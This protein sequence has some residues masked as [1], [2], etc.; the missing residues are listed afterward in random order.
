ML[1]FVEPSPEE[2]LCHHSEGEPT[3][4]MISISINLCPE[5]AAC[6]RREELLTSS[7]LI[8]HQPSP[9]EAL[10]QQPAL[11]GGAQARALAISCP[12]R[13]IRPARGQ[14]PGLAW[15]SG[16][17]A[18]LPV[19]RGPRLAWLGGSVV[20]LQAFLKCPHQV[21]VSR[22]QGPHGSRAPS[23][24]NR[25]IASGHKQFHHRS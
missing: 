1:R 23:T 7:S 12:G 14:G 2:A 18:L 19:G 15:F 8:A 3:S 22:A 11:S 4:G 13:G 17:F 24:I 21:P 20:S 6:Q 25:D 10:C 5:E 16:F 9:E